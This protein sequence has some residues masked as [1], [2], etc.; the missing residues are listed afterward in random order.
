[1]WENP[2]KY[3]AGWNFG[4]DNEDVVS[5]E[6]IVKRVIQIWSSGSY[7]VNREQSLHE[8]QLLKLDISKARFN[9]KWKPVFT[10]YKALEHTINWYKEFYSGNKNEMYQF[11]INQ[12]QEYIHSAQ[13]LNLEWSLSK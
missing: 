3:C 2:T 7:H 12:I 6:D 8:A 5:V 1:M 10:A 11:T 4:P 9:L 13:K